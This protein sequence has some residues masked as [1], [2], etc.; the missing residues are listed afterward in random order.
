[1]EAV[2]VFP[3]ALCDRLVRAG[4]IA[5]LVIDNVDHAVRT[6][7]ALWQGGVEIAEVT[8]R[9][10]A[11]TES[12]AL[13]SKE[14]PQMLPVAGTVL[15][16]SQVDLAI[17]AGAAMA[18][19]PGFQRETVLHAQQGG[20]PFAPGMLTP[21]EI[22]AAIALGCRTLKFFPAATAGGLPLLKS[23]SAPY[24]HLGLNFLPTGSI[25]EEAMGDYL[26]FPATMAVGGSWIA[27]RSVIQSEEWEE[28]TRRAQRAR[29]I[30]DSIRQK[31]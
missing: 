1:M 7:Q 26:A 20:L 24:H 28:I 22:E 14:L 30:V 2:H 3:T 21:T 17:D 19:A 8:M 15:S 18:V 5:V 13:I 10:A 4:A 27:P 29:K 6:A 9:T 16:P 11:A 25:S 23:V 31:G 12:L